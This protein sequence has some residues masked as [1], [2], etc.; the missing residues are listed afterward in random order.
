LAHRTIEDVEQ[1]LTL[2]WKKKKN[3]QEEGKHS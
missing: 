2:S 1:P 3:R